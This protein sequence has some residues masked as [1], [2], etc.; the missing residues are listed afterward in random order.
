MHPREP[1]P[2]DP[3]VQTDDATRSRH[4]GTITE[5]ETTSAITTP[6]GSFAAR[7]K[8]LSHR[9]DDGDLEAAREIAKT[10]AECAG[11]PDNE[12]SIA[13][14][15]ILI[16]PD[17]TMGKRLASRPQA[18]AAFQKGLDVDRARLQ[19]ARDKCAGITR[20]QIE[21]RAHWLYKS[22]E[23]GDADSALAFGRGDFLF[24][25]LASIES[26]DQIPFWREHA[27]DMLER[28]LQGGKIQ[29]ALA[30]AQGH[31]PNRELDGSEVLALSDDPVAAYAYYSALRMS[32]EADVPMIAV[33]RLAAQL[34]DPERAEAERQAAEIC[35]TAL[36]G[37]CHPLPP[38]PHE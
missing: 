25:T 2:P 7:Y 9:A 23:L 36:G 17:S 10:L 8:E 33:E 30:L 19:T 13:S 14:T 4:S 5:R 29:A 18:L 16:D 3:T 31:D 38:V 26:L 28:A 20:N 6:A 22:A 21:S 27:E 35:A 1:R 34:S 11:I 24:S 12:R 15:R 32:G 37:R